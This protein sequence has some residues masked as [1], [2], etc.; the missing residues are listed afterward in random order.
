MDNRLLLREDADVLLLTISLIVVVFGAILLVIKKRTDFRQHKTRDRT[1]V[2]ML[3]EHRRFIQRLDHELKNPLT[4]LHAGLSTLRLTVPEQQ[5]LTRTL[6]IEVRRVSNLVSSLRKLVELEAVSLDITEIDLQQ[7]VDVL[8]E[9]IDEREDIRDRQFDVRLPGH[10]P[11]DHRFAGD[12]DL[13]LLAVHNLLDNALKYS[14]PGAQIMLAFAFHDDAISI[15]VSDTGIGIPEREVRLVREEL[16]RG[17]NV[18]AIPGSGI[19]LSLV[20][21]IVERHDGE[22]RIRSV[23]GKG[24]TVTLVLPLKPPIQKP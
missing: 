24:T 13:L 12:H 6:L 11:R 9:L 8:V 19:G 18:R 16:Y 4:A 23:E 21:A 3:A 17:N 1:R 5:D 10:R 2:E 7:F 15:E 22:L 20:Q 14:L